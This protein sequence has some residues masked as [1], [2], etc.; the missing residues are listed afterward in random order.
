MRILESEPG[1]SGAMDRPAIDASRG[2]ADS[3][4][5]TREANEIRR[6]AKIAAYEKRIADCAAGFAH[7]YDLKRS[8]FNVEARLRRL[9]ARQRAFEN[10]IFGLKQS[11]LFAR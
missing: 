9:G 3:A 10:R 2:R 11:D 1:G 6:A 4:Q 5:R 7:L 8:G